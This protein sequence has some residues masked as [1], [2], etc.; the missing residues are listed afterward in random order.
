[1]AYL[2][3]PKCLEEFSEVL[4]LYHGGVLEG[5]GDY[6]AGK[7]L[8]AVQWLAGMAKLEARRE[9]D[10]EKDTAGRGCGGP[11]ANHG[12]SPCRRGIRRHSGRA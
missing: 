10:G 4:M 11:D 2:H 12:Y 8:A 3:S 1:M 7:T 6:N 5:Q 9:G